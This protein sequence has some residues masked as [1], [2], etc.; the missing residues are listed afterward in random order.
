MNL[1][2][3][4]ELV[5]A[6]V[7]WVYAFKITVYVIAWAYVFVSVCLCICDVSTYRT[8][9]NKENIEKGICIPHIA[10]LSVSFSIDCLFGVRWIDIWLVL[11]FGCKIRQDE[12]PNLR[13]LCCA[14]TSY[15]T[16]AVA[17]SLVC[18]GILPCRLHRS[19]FTLGVHCFVFRLC[20]FYS[21][22][23]S[24]PCF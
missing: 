6:C 17:K 2:M 12:Q 5:C 23:F 21:W 8:T 18:K 24:Y 4:S 13:Q 7:L 3:C 20:T 22:Q 14:Q 9:Y 15:G 11:L 16:N 1:C 19:N 10:F